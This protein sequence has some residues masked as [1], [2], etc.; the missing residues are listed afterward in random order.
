MGNAQGQPAT[1][2]ATQSKQMDTATFNSQTGA[3][4]V[5]G[6]V[7][8]PN[9]TTDLSQYLSMV[10]KYATT[11]QPGGVY[12]KGFNSINLKTPEPAKS[13]PLNLPALTIYRIESPPTRAVVYT[14]AQGVS[15]FCYGN[16]PNKLIQLI[17]GGSMIST[18]VKN[19]GVDL[20]KTNR[21]TQ[22]PV[23]K[24]TGPSPIFAPSPVSKPTGPSQIFTPTPVSK[25]SGPTPVSKPSG[26]TATS[27][28]TETCLKT[29]RACIASVPDSRTPS[30]GT[31]TYQ[32]DGGGPSLGETSS[33]IIKI[34]FAFVVIT[35]A[36]TTATRK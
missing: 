2:S 25:P 16:D 6:S 34:L 22:P 17:P 29:L 20:M 36:V 23:S 10:Q 21:P 26:P 18:P 15:N 4:S 8:Q 35:F 30:T 9:D 12:P 27:G 13:T 14:N 33:N 32:V 19:T 24:P 3:L 5:G 28:G 11:G 1:Q 31:S 7:M